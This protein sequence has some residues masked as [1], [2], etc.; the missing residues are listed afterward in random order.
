MNNAD[1]NV[2]AAEKLEAYLREEMREDVDVCPEEVM[3]MKA[4]DE[5]A[6]YAASIGMEIGENYKEQPLKELQRMVVDFQ[7]EQADGM[8]G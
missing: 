2:L 4:K 6:A 5:V 7:E 8:G 3:K 1:L